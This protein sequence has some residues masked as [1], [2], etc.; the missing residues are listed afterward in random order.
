[1]RYSVKFSV[2]YTSVRNLYRKSKTKYQNAGMHG[3]CD[4]SR[5]PTLALNKCEKQQISYSSVEYVK[6]KLKAPGGGGS[7]VLIGQIVKLSLRQL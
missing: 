3:C 4:S 5:R 2:L 6:R 1:M 7:T